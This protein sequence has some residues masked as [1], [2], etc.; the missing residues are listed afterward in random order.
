[1]PDEKPT[2]LDVREVR[3][4]DLLHLTRAASPQFAQ[5]IMVRVIRALPDRH[6]YHGW[7]WIE[8]YQLGPNG[9]A[10]ERRELFV[11]PAGV[12]WMTSASTPARRTPV[13]VGR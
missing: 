13:G 3:S 6:T 11:M 12:R 2:P 7:L 10:I 5:P 8:A 9:D 4:G 1:M